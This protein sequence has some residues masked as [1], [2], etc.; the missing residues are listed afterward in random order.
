MS[1]PGFSAETLALLASADWRTERKRAMRYINAG[2]L[3]A[4]FSGLLFSLAGLL[5]GALVWRIRGDLLLAGLAAMSGVL[6][7]LVASRRGR[8]ALNADPLL[9]MGAV[10]RKGQ[11][12]TKK[13]RYRLAVVMRIDA[14]WS[15]DLDTGPRPRLDLCGERTVFARDPVYATTE[16][17]SSPLTGLVCLPTGD[18]LFAWGGPPAGAILTSP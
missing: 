1:A 12:P 4:L 17:G 8:K 6:A 14:A 18:A 2:G 3:V 5:A 11:V 10:L 15:L 16:P 9:V 7:G 13:G